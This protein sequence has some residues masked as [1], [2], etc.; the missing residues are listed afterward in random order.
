VILFGGDNEYHFNSPIVRRRFKIID[1]IDRLI[2]M[3]EGRRRSRT[4][5]E[6]NWLISEG[7]PII[8]PPENGMAE[9]GELWEGDKTDKEKSVEQ[10]VEY[11]CGWALDHV[12]CFR[13]FIIVDPHERPQWREKYQHVT[14]L[15][16]DRYLEKF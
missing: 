5:D 13:R 9:I 8:S 6:H 12:H 10:M 16:P 3:D 14:V 11:F 15:T 7:G 2:D 1:E 4:A